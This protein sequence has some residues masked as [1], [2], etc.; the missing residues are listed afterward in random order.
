MSVRVKHFNPEEFK[1][2]IQGVSWLDVYLSENV[3][4]AVKLMSDKITSILDIMAPMRTVQIRT[5][6]SP[7]LSQETK[8]LMSER[9]S[10]HSRAAQSRDKEDWRKYKVIR[11][12]INSRLK[13]EER[14]WQRL[15]ITECGQNSAKVWKNVKDIINLK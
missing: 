9:N 10:L 13:Y 12:K 5:N 8:D 4:H 11:N 3:N 7:W 15:R 14:S 6:Y 1:A 2:A